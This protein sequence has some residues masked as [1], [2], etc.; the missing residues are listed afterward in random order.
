MVD[1]LYHVFVERL[2]LH[3]GR[4]AFHVHQHNTGSVLFHNFPHI[5]A[6]AHGIDVI[7]DMCAGLQSILRHFALVC[8]YRNET[9]H[10]FTQFFDDRNNPSEFLLDCQGS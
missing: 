2:H 5:I 1:L 9:F 10:F 7:D 4:T 6:V 8:I 3:I